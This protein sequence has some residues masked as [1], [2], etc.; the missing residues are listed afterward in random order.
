[1]KRFYGIA[2][3]HRNIDVND[4]SFRPFQVRDNDAVT[5]VT[6]KFPSLLVSQ[7][8]DLLV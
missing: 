5:I 2:F 8:V 1:M 6:S 3:W 4:K 7:S